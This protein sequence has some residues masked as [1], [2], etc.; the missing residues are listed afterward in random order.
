MFIK[1]ISSYPIDLKLL[2]QSNLNYVYHAHITTCFTMQ[3]TIPVS[4]E[5]SDGHRNWDLISAKTKRAMG[6]HHQYD[7]EFW[8]DFFKDFC[9]EFEEVN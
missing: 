1:S 3:A 6:L 8:M 2:Y 7:G 9:R 4:G 5:W